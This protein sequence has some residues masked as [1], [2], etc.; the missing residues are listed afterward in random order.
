MARPGAAIPTTGR[1]LTSLP[2]SEPTNNNVGS[3]VGI[4]VSV[5]TKGSL[6]A[7]FIHSDTIVEFELNVGQHLIPGEFAKVWED[8]TLVT[9]PTTAVMVLGSG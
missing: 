6:K 4:W 5:A 9:E 1:M 8:N 7:K 3:S 2:T